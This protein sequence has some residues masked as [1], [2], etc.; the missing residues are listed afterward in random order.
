MTCSVEVQH[1][2][3]G[4]WPTSVE[5][6]EGYLEKWLAVT[7]ETTRPLTVGLPEYCRLQVSPK[8]CRGMVS[9]ARA[10]VNDSALNVSIAAILPCAPLLRP[11]AHTS[12]RSAV[13]HD[14]YLSRMFWK[15]RG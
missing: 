3:L 2:V 9:L 10:A 12:A 11:L 15:A 1:I 5:W 7:L 13:R 6:G 14:S 8:R 4:Q